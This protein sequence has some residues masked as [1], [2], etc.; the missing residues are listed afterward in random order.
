MAE[1]MFDF[2]RDKV[3][4]VADVV[5]TP[6]EPSPAPKKRAAPKPKAEPGSSPVAPKPRGRKKQIVEAAGPAPGSPVTPMSAT[7]PLAVPAPVLVAVPVKKSD[8]EEEDYDV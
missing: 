7:A 2:L 1:N 5:D 8:E 3:A 4:S 6:A